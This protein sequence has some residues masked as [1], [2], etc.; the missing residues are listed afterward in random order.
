[1]PFCADGLVDSDEDADAGIRLPA[2]PK[3]F[4]AYD[5]F[6]RDRDRDAKWMDTSMT[7]LNALF[8]NIFA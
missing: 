6:T 7:W 3:W 8:A 4:V 2:A 1:M 5:K